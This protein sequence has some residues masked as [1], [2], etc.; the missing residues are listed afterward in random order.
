MN[1]LA[2]GT[3]MRKELQDTSYLEAHPQACEL[4][5]EVG[6][7]RFCQKLQGYHQGITESFSKSFDGFKVQ[8]EPMVMQIDE[9]SF[10]A[11]TDMP[12]EGERWFMTTSIKE[13]D[14]KCFLKEKNQNM[15]WKK[16]IP[17]SYLEDKWKTLLKMI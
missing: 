15:K 7:Y 10:V 5:K 17:R 11:A 1:I 9:S 12:R 13:V 2:E 14:F 6:C 16:D 4:F 3:L 8:L